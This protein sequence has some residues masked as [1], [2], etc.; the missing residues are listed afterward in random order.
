MSCCP[1]TSSS[2]R[3]K[4]TCRKASSLSKETTRMYGGPALNGF[5]P[6]VV[7]LRETIWSIAPAPRLQPFCLLTI[8]SEPPESLL[9]TPPHQS[10]ADWQI[11]HFH[12]LVTAQK[13]LLLEV[14]V[15][16]DSAEWAEQKGRPL[17]SPLVQQQF[18]MDDLTLVLNPRGRFLICTLPWE[19]DDLQF[20]LDRLNSE[21]GAHTLLPARQEP[22]LTVQR[23]PRNQL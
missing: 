13:F 4:S 1:R 20:F 21:I 22:S 19:W 23:A 10:P 17:P 5:P 3:A 16:P 6:F 11:T 9:P 12:L 8:N 7:W 14:H 15:Q 18:L 2:R